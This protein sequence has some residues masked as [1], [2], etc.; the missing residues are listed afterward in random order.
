M[1]IIQWVGQLLKKSGGT[2][3]RRQTIREIVTEFSARFPVANAQKTFV[4]MVGLTQTGKT[5]YVLRHPQLRHFTRIS[6]RLIHQALNLKLGDWQRTET[7]CAESYQV[8]QELE[9]AIRWQLLTRAFQSG[10]AVVDD[11]CNL[12]RD[13]RRRIL[14]LANSY[15]YRTILIWMDYGEDCLNNRIR[16]ACR[17]DEARNDWLPWVL[18]DLQYRSFDRPYSR[19]ADHQD[20]YLN[21]EAIR[22]L[23]FTPV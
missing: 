20:Y 10:L 4:V 17:F 12:N 16:Q 23:E 8:R 3:T 5:T 19:E 14:A 15:G 2:E 22:R 13:W 7:G 6:S 21:G 9:Q 1:R 11:S 18:R